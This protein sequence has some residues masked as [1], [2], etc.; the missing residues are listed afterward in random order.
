MFYCSGNAAN[1]FKAK[2]EGFARQMEGQVKAVKVR[3][4]APSINASPGY[5]VIQ[6]EIRFEDASEA[7][8][9]QQLQLLLSAEP[10][11]PVPLRQVRTHTPLYLSVFVCG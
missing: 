1:T 6:T 3:E 4:L 11:K 7:A 9:A 8:V 5:G 10:A 2:A